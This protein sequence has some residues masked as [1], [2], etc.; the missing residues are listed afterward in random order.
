M[1]FGRCSAAQESLPY[2]ARKLG[3]SSHAASP[4]RL[5]SALTP[6]AAASPAHFDGADGPCAAGG[7]GGGEGES[8][9]AVYGEED[10]DALTR[11]LEPLREGPSPGRDGLS[12]TPGSVLRGPAPAVDEDGGFSVFEG[13][14]RCLAACSGAAAG[15]GAAAAGFS[16]AAAASASDSTFSFAIYRDET[17]A[18]PPVPSLPPPPSQPAGRPAL[19]PLAAVSDENAAAPAAAVGEAAEA[20]A[21][22]PAGAG[23]AIFCDESSLQAAF[24]GFQPAATPVGAAVEEAAPAAE[25]CN[26]ATTAAPLDPAALL[27]LGPSPAA[28]PQSSQRPAQQLPQDDTCEFRELDS[29]GALQSFLDNDLASRAVPAPQQQQPQAEPTMTLGLPVSS[30]AAILGLSS[31]EDFDPDAGLDD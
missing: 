4:L 27:P 22:A 31:W 13:E 2:E 21:A 8:G 11:G 24:G 6:L 10:G 1:C 20:E 19:A 23:F 29:T 28:A 26:D 14:T 30:A 7:G 5:P 18:L 25:D 3:R 9:F 16:A 17:G 15:E 12:G